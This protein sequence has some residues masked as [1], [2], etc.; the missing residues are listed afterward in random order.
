MY[1]HLQAEVTSTNPSGHGDGRSPEQRSIQSSQTLDLPL[2]VTNSHTFASVFSLLRPR[3][4]MLL[5][6]A[7]SRMVMPMLRPAVPRVV[8]FRSRPVAICGSRLASTV[9]SDAGGIELTIHDDGFA[10][11]TMVRPDQFNTFND[12]LIKRFT[13][14]W[15]DLAERQG[16]LLH[17]H[18]PCISASKC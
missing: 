14:I 13:E 4:T 12:A 8:P 1:S 10:D 15:D 9:V 3:V 17:G 16:T 6:R 5:T 18:A 7:S 2:Q 11:V